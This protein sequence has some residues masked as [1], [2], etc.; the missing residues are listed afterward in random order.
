MTNERLYN[1]KQAG[2][3]LGGLCAREVRREIKA[4]RLR[5]KKRTTSRATGKMPRLF[6]PASAINEYIAALPNATA[7]DVTSNDGA[8]KRKDTR[9]QA[10]L[11]SVPDRFSK[12]H[13]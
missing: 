12:G 3:L 7:A 9:L 10:E 2:M 6:V 4:E 13:N 1:L 11:D 8:F 5:A